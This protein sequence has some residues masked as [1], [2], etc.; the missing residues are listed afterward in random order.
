MQPDIGQ[1][2]HVDRQESVPL[3]GVAP[4][5]VDVEAESPGVV[6]PDLGLVRCRE[7]PANLVERLQVSGRIGSSRP[8]QR[9]LVE[10]HDVGHVTDHN[11]FVVRGGAYA[12]AAGMLA[13]RGEERLLDQGAL[14]RAA[15]SG[16]DAENAE[17][18]RDVD[19]PEVVAAGSFHG[20]HSPRPR[21]ATLGQ[22][23]SLASGQV[24]ARGRTL[25]KGKTGDRAGVEYFTA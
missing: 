11:Q 9:R 22:G 8:G 15:D 21:P 17:G 5:A 18:E 14:P 20:E 7:G 24:V 10:K 12:L 1:E 23:H 13:E 25:R 2:L 16:D 4:S 3:T 6:V 19:R